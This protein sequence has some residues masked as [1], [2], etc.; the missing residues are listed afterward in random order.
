MKVE[1]TDDALVIEGERKHE[2]EDKQ[3]GR[4]HSERSYGR[5]HRTIPLPEGATAEQ[6]RA[7]FKNGELQITVPIQRPQSKRRQIPITGASTQ[8]ETK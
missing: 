8:P 3:E 4:W 6:A 2:R 7:D 5:F 1:I